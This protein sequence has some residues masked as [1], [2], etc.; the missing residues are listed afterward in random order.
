MAGDG[1]VSI[2]A[3][4]DKTNVD[5]GLGET[6]EMVKASMESLTASVTEAGAKTKAAWKGISDEAKAA[7]ASMSADALKVAETSKAVAATQAEVRRAWTLSKDAAIPLEQSMGIL[8]ATQ[9]RLSEAQTA[10]AAAVKANAASMAVAA[11]EMAVSAAP[12]AAA[13]EAAGV[14]I[15]ATLKGVQGQIVET[16]AVAKIGAGGMT[17][18]FL[19]LGPAMMAVGAAFMA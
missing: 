16:A 10:N 12:V 3:T 19:G 6:Q 2:G 14:E 1:V 13:W 4:F 7:A 11:D 9:V 18:A 15:N 17:A 8:A 5:A